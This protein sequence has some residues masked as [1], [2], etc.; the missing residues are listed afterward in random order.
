MGR[1]II[2]GASDVPA[3]LLQSEE[4]LHTK[5]EAEHLDQGAAEL[6]AIRLEVQTLKDPGDFRMV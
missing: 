5:S 1:E 3:L 6:E 2:H 4:S